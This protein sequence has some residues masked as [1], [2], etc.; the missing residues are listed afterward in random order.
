M[1]LGELSWADTR[2]F[3]GIPG[4]LGEIRGIS[5]APPGLSGNFG[6]FSGP[7]RAD[8]EGIQE[9]SRK[10]FKSCRLLKIFLKP[11]RI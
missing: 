8:S 4:K 7:R 2:V 5:G 11:C 3:T 10:S 1:N 6:E 9:T